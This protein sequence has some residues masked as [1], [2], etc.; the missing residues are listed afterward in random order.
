MTRVTTSQAQSDLKKVIWR[1][2]ANG[3]RIVLRQSGKDVAAL[4]SM[5][6]FK[7]LEKMR[8]KAELQADAV[9]FKRAK[10]EFDKSGGQGIPL[11]RIKKRLGL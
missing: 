1:V 6:E 2:A 7:S 9:A 4:I 5:E 3:E 8:K 10:R 11:D